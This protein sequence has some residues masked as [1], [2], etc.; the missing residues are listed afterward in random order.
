MKE[1]TNKYN[2]P[3]KI[4]DLV[5]AENRPPQPHRYSVTELNNSVAE[6]IL[7]RRYYNYYVPDVSDYT[8]MLFGTAFH[9]LFDDGSEYAEQK[10]EVEFNGTTIVGIIDRYENNEITD[11]KTTTS[12]K[13]KSGDFSDWDSQGGKYAW[14]LYKRG[15][16]A[17]KVRFIAFIK[18]WSR[19]QA[20]RDKNYPQSQI[21]EHVFYPKINDI[22]KTE[23]D[24]E[25]KI[26]L[27]EDNLETPDNLLPY[28]SDDELWF[29][30]NKYAVM[31]QSSARAV[32]ICDTYNEADELVKAGRGNYIETRYGVYNK[33]MHDDELRVLF[34]KAGLRTLPDAMI[35]YI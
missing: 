31:R 29:T 27:I 11:Y 26:K 23:S 32:K 33:L 4:V 7:K 19:S 17:N 12:Y 6:I 22:L 18:D 35:K 30:G 24:L 15:Y 1:I 5:T 14:L 21:Y 25:D 16:I 34:E 28:P 8:N 10:Y 13:I 3:R 2:L 9:N 20:R